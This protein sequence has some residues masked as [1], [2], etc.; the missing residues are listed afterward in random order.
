MLNPEPCFSSLLISF[1]K[2]SKVSTSLFFVS[3]LSAPLIS[4]CLIYFLSCYFS[5]IDRYIFIWFFKT[6]VHLKILLGSFLFFSVTSTKEGRCLSLGCTGM[7]E[8]TWLCEWP[9][10]GVHKAQKY[11]S[12]GAKEF[13]MWDITMSLNW[14]SIYS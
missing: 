7:Y 8:N 11:L 14:V 13:I 3:H 10:L 2:L 12:P 6:S 5:H 9:K 4:L 1:S